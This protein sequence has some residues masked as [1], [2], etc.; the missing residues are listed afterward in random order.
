MVYSNGLKQGNYPSKYRIC[1]I[2][3]PGEL[4]FQ[5]QLLY[6]TCVV[7][8]GGGGGIIRKGGGEIIQDGELIFR[9][10]HFISDNEIQF[11]SLENL[12]G[13]R[14]HD[15]WCTCWALGS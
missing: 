7:V 4:I 10:W 15:L 1:A 11:E 14:T 13:Q 3:F 5:H 9:C 8:V 6:V 12:F 2:Y